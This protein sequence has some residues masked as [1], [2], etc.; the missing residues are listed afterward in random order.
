MAGDD[1]SCLLKLACQSYGS[2]VFLKDLYAMCFFDKRQFIGQ[3]RS[4]VWLPDI[5]HYAVHVSEKEINS[6]ILS[7]ADSW[8]T[9]VFV[10]S[11]GMR[12]DV[13]TYENI[14][15][16][17]LIL[18]RDNS[19]LPSGIRDDKYPVLLLEPRCYKQRQIRS[20][21]KSKDLLKKH[22][23]PYVEYRSDKFSKPEARQTNGCDQWRSFNGK[24]DCENTE[25]ETLNKSDWC[26]SSALEG[27]LLE[28]RTG[29]LYLVMGYSGS[30]LVNSPMS[31]HQIRA[32]SVSLCDNNK[33]LELYGCLL[34]DM[35]LLAVFSHVKRLFI[36]SEVFH[37][38]DEI[39][40]HIECEPLGYKW[41]FSGKA[42]K[43]I[44]QTMSDK[45]TVVF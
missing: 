13:T 29:R 26:D 34:K 35:P 14:F 8:S 41:F 21:I 5:H 40:C 25:D 33:T 12:H 44:I 39:K 23:I 18:S 19:E 1:F 9:R 38:C 10:R 20:Y 22:L 28:D 31:F 36:S 6:G 11:T 42:F 37:C 32:L 45:T 17:V 3:E 16:E 15:S 30:D 7:L 43:A 2:V 24:G 27:V 4:V